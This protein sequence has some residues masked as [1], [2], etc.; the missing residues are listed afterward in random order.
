MECCMN[1][2]DFAPYI[3]FLAAFYLSL[4]FEGLIRRFF[5]TPVFYRKLGD[6][7]ILVSQLYG[8]NEND[9][10]HR[11]TVQTRSRF[12]DGG[13]WRDI[14]GVIVV[15]LFLLIISSLELSI[16]EVSFS[17]E[18]NSWLGYWWLVIIV[19]ITLP[20]LLCICYAMYYSFF[21]IRQ[22][23]NDLLN[24]NKNLAQNIR[25]YVSGNPDGC[26]D[27]FKNTFLKQLSECK[28]ADKDVL[29]TRVREVYSRKSFNELLNNI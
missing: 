23:N 16:P 20:A 29:L 3:Q 7:Y 24:L 27:S 18:K 2:N 14:S 17:W 28:S 21:R 26:D 13:W 15:C 25:C 10:A 4:G 6:M 9:R 22:I 8:L 1:L 12:A 11:N 19:I 5:F